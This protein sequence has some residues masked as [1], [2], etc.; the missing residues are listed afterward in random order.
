MRFSFGRTTNI[1]CFWQ[2]E[3]GVDVDSPTRRRHRV[4]RRK[5]TNS[6]KL[7][8]LL[9]FASGP[10]ISARDRE[11]HAACFPKRVVGAN[12]VHK[13]AFFRHTIRL[14]RKIIVHL[15]NTRRHTRTITGARG[16]ML[17]KITFPL[18][19]SHYTVARNNPFE[20]AFAY[21]I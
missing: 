5:K 17:R 12:S 7:C 20:R 6:K 4:P 13:C 8:V 10:R 18:A 1:F 3:L 21:V 9:D 11:V 16:T 2:Q 15:H 14:N 19:L